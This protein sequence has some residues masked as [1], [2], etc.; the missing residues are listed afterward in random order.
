MLN[1]DYR[2]TLAQ[3]RTFV[4]VAENRHFGLAASKLG[5][6]QPSLSQA[7][8][9]LENGL[10]IQLIERSTRKVLVTPTG[11]ELLPL[12]KATLDAA[13]AFL[14]RSK[15][16]QGML[17]GTLTIGVIPTVAPYLLPRL[18]ELIKTEYPDLELSIVE[19]QTHH[20]EDLLRDGHVDIALMAVPSEFSGMREIPLYHEDFV[21]VVPESHR[22]AGRRNLSLS[23]LDKL[24]LLLLDDG[25]CLHDQIVELC[26]QANVNPSDAAHA[27]TRAS[28]LTTVM[29]LV[30]AGLGS[31]LIPIS[32]LTTECQRPGLAIATFAPEVTAHRQIGLVYRH[33][34][35]REDEFHAFG[36]LIAQAFKET[37]AQS[38]EL[39]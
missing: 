4:T 35:A 38:R 28:S 7:L 32:A 17:T 34:S 18:L 5:I 8:V 19:D 14:S 10:G 26:R 31:T 20:L 6:S 2:P 21:V 22:F 37:A 3:L 9:A 11:L 27:I 15:G 39:L 30:I 36:V 12:A 33:S 25:H 24:D 16:V 29:Q 23:S 1:K 13:D